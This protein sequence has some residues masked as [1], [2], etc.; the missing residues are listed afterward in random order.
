MRRGTR[1]AADDCGRASESASYVIK[2]TVATPV[3][4]DGGAAIPA[5]LAC[6]P[7]EPVVAVA[8]SIGMF[9]GSR[10]HGMLAGRERQRGKEVARAIFGI[11]LANKCTQVLRLLPVCRVRLV[12]LMKRLGPLFI[13]GNSYSPSSC[14]DP[15]GQSAAC[16]ASSR[17]CGG[18]A[19]ARLTQASASSPRRK[20]VGS[21]LLPLLDVRIPTAEPFSLLLRAAAPPHYA[22]GSAGELGL[23]VQPG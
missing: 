15:G 7:G 16:L 4:V 12:R 17:A 6:R 10:V 8:L 11:I 22:A 3:R 18:D 2:I 9:C 1:P 14:L 23:P 5:Q 13:P 19:V 20:G 21:F